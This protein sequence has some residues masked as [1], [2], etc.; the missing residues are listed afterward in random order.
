MEFVMTVRYDVEVNEY[1]LWTSKLERIPLQLQLREILETEPKEF[2][3]SFDITMRVVEEENRIYAS[4]EGVDRK[5]EKHYKKI[6]GG[7]LFILIHNMA[8]YID[9]VKWTYIACGG[10]LINNN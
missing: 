5:W 7:T 3:K 4:M 6:D 10:N 9:A 1:D 2:L 8:D